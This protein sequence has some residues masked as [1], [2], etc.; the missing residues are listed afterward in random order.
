MAC[1]VLL[2]PFDVRCRLMVKSAV[3]LGVTQCATSG[4]R[5]LSQAA[6]VGA[7]RPGLK[8]VGEVSEV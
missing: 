6:L 1:V 8:L 3:P 4:L 2:P 5:E 7:M